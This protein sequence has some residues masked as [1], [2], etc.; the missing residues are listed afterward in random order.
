MRPDK[1]K[2]TNEVWDTDRGRSFLDKT[3]MGHEANADYSILLYAYRSMRAEDFAEFIGYYT[4]EG[5]DLEATSNRG[6][7]LLQTIS[8]HRHAQPFMDILERAAKHR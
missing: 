4:T 6:E 8:R 5:H 2:V 3:P 1:K 7:T